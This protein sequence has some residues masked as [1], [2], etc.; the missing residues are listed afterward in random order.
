[1]SLMVAIKG[2][3]VILGL[4]KCNYSLT[5][6]NELY[7]WPL[8][9]NHETDVAPSENEFDTPGL[10]PLIKCFNYGNCFLGALY[11]DLSTKSL[12]MSTVSDPE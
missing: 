2:L 3:N 7:I 1:M 12:Q 6:G 4:Y 9:G 11:G 10:D 5:T 8:E